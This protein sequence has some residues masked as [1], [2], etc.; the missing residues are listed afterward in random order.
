MKTSTARTAKDILNDITKYEV[1]IRRLT[2]PLTLMFPLVIGITVAR[3]IHD[4]TY[5]SDRLFPLDNKTKLIMKRFHKRIVTSYKNT[6]IEL[7]Q[8]LINL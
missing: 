1:E 5:N 6:I 2:M 8:E 3:N 4:A 7:K